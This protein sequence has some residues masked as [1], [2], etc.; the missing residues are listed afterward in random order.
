VQAR[1]SN[2]YFLSPLYHA[3]PKQVGARLEPI[4]NIARVSEVS[5]YEAGEGQVVIGLDIPEP[6]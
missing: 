6:D 3:V 4:I 5:E 1:T 2:V